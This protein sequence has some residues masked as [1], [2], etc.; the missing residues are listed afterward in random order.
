[1]LRKTLIGATAVALLACTQLP[2]QAAAPDAPTDLQIGWASTAE[3]IRVSWTD[4]GEANRIY[5]WHDG[6]TQPSLLSRTV[7]GGTNE[8][9]LP[10]RYFSSS[11]ITRIVVTTVDAAGV[12][13]TRTESPRFDADRPPVPVLTDATPLAD[14][15]LRLT[16]TQPAVPADETPDDPLDRPWTEAKVGPAIWWNSGAPKAEEFLKPLGTTTAIVPPRPRPFPAD[17]T[18]RNEWGAVTSDRTVTF[19]TTALTLGVPATNDFGRGMPIQGV[20]GPR[21]IAPSLDCGVGDISVVMTLQSRAN[22]SKP[23]AYAGR[24]TGKSSGYLNYANV[25]GSQQYRLYMPTWKYFRDPHWTVTSPVSTTARY[26]A[27]QTFFRV[28][29]FNTLNAQVGQALK[30]TVEINPAATVKASLQ[31]YDG[32]VWHHAAY[33]PLS[34]GKGTLNVK[35]AGKGTTRYWRVAVPQMTYNGL[36]LVATGS[37]AFKL[38]VR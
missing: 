34:K 18:A 17:V 35:A 9:L 5:L 36:P 4:G 16:W 29:G 15:S 20:A 21:C 3:Q 23:W 7:V 10:T 30:T 2:A 6:S 22:A 32:K 12:E 8:K 24:F 13:S 25:F 19:A 14:Q 38:T 1:M 26:S 28:A 33:I 37:R 27:T 31:W 11:W